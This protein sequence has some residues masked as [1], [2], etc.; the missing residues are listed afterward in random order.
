MI[1]SIATQLCGE[2]FFTLKAKEMKE[3]LVP[4]TLTESLEIGKTIRLA[5]EEGRD[6]VRAVTDFLNGWILFKGK[7]EKKDWEDREGYMYGTTYI[8]GIQEFQGEK[9]K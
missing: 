5:R 6:P 4:G 8:E 9:L 1:S 3:I 2:T 7:V